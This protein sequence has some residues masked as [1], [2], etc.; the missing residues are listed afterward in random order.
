MLE[1]SFASHNYKM[2]TYGSATASGSSEKGEGHAGGRTSA[3]R[4]VNNTILVGPVVSKQSDSATRE[5]D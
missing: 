2:R 5:L 1:L 3:G 4:G